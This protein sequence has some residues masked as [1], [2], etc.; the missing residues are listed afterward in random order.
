M[1][2]KELLSSGNQQ[3]SLNP[4]FVKVPVVSRTSICLSLEGF[5]RT[6]CGLIYGECLGPFESYMQKGFDHQTHYLVVL[7]Q[8]GEVLLLSCFSWTN[9]FTC[10]L[11][12]WFWLDTIVYYYLIGIFNCM[13]AG[14]V[15]QASLLQTTRYRL[16]RVGISALR[17]HYGCRDGSHDGV[18]SRCASSCNLLR[19]RGVAA[20]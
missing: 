1:V 10:I 8:F 20:A 7:V 11:K 18:T 4:L 12:V 3:I 19:H 2:H 13:I 9:T 15:V 17:P 14:L 5:E 16:P 6:V